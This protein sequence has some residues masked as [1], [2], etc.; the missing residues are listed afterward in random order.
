MSDDDLKPCTHCG[1]PAYFLDE[2]DGIGVECF[3]CGLEQRSNS[4]ERAGMHWNR[5]T[6]GPA[7]KA[8]LEWAEKAIREIEER[9][10]DFDRQN[11]C[12]PW[13]AMLLRFLA[14]WEPPAA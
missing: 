6:P 9:E 4:L 7:T 8:M 5:R 2:T 12:N 10:P 3:H 13:I 14:E 11:N 1:G